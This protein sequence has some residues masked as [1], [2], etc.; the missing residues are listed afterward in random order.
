MNP[1]R[2]AELHHVISMLLEFHKKDSG[3]FANPVDAIALGVAEYSDLITL[4]MDLRTMKQ[5]L[6][7]GLYHSVEAFKR[8]FKLIIANTVHYNGTENPITQCGLRLAK[9]FDQSMLSLLGDR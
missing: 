4:P 8:D 2:I 6:N 1:T 7:E 3:P 9:I 5:K